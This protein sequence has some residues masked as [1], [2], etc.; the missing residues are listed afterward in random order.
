MVLRV[1]FGDGRSDWIAV[2]PT[3]RKLTAGKF[4]GT[5]IALCARTDKD[6]NQTA[7]EVFGVE[8]LKK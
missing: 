5:G 1:V 2:A 7:L 3:G 8:P 6:G 4:S